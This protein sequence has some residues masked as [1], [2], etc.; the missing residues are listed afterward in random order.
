MSQHIPHLRIGCAA[1]FSGDRTDAAAP[2][3][4]ALIAS[5]QPAV[6]IFET[7]AE[8]TIALAQLRR[9]ADPDAGYDPMLKARMRAVLDNQSGYW[10][11]GMHIKALAQSAEI[12]VTLAVKK[13][14]VQRLDGKQVIFVREGNV[15]TATMPE[16]GREDDEYI[17]V[18][19][20][21]APGSEYASDN[22]FVLKA[23][24]LKSGASH[25]H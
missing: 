2:V 22:S 23:D 12:P 9:V 18:V 15:F 11:P 25:A 17:E 16:F 4:Q 20:G 19:S 14:A 24:A 1:G 6:L 7:L 3:V 8:R 13:Q 10:R 21:L 5:G